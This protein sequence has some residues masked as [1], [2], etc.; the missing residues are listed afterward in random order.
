MAL[1]G[2]SSAEQFTSA[3]VL[4]ALHDV[5]TDLGGHARV[6]QDAM[7][8]EVY[9][10]L[11]DGGHLMVQAGTGTGKSL[12][13]LVPAL[14]WAD[15]N[16]TRVVIS[17]ATLALQRQIMTHDAP[18]VL[19]YFKRRGKIPPRI[20]LLK[21][22][23][24]YVCLRKASGGYPDDGALLSR[25]EGEYGATATGEQ[26]TRARDWAMST[27]T[28]DRDDLVP[29]V[30]ERAWAQISIPKSEC[31]GQS[32]PLRDACF[33]RLARIEAEKASVVVTNHAMLGVAT[34]GAQVLPD[35]DAF[36]VDEAHDLD[37]RV[38][39]QLTQTLMHTEI[40]RVA[41][42]LRRNG[43]DDLELE[44]CADNLDTEMGFLPEGR[45][46]ELPEGLS[47]VVLQLLG[48]LQNASEELSS[49]SVKGEEQSAAKQILRSR[50]MEMMTFCTDILGDGL[51]TKRSVAWK[52]LWG[53]DTPI[54]NLAPM[55]IA[56]NLAH[57]L[58]SEHAAVLTSATLKLGGSFDA[59]ARRVGFTLDDV[60]HWHGLDVGT[61]F[62]TVNQGVLYVAKHLPVPGREG[63][64]EEHLKEL[65]ELIRASRGG[66]LALF[67][68][69]A[70]AQRASEY[71]RHELPY[72]ILLQGEDQ[73]P[74]LVE[75]FRDSDSACLFG[76]YSLWQGVDV[77]GRTNRLVVI[78]R[79]PFPRPDDPLTQARTEVAQEHHH[80][81]FMNVSAT[82]AALLL[83]QGAGRL[84]RTHEDKGVVAILDSRIATR[85][86]SRFLLD[87]LPPMW[88]TTRQDVVLGV[89]QRLSSK[90]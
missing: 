61:P 73:L 17:T 76:T 77:P 65:T 83:A 24:N 81:G 59:I 16:N 35:A 22:W 33:P 78:D 89:L 54:L 2:D 47:G 39:S 25:A 49:W 51:A 40:K 4:D 52:S 44:I 64:G 46:T 45:I 28:G 48:Q 69:R 82:H 14:L 26:V 56:W 41:R 86:Y 63:Y 70:A 80:N 58:F 57:T 13:Y 7:A 11:L 29:G 27:D 23:N 55:N 53:D 74:T 12:G 60:G 30:S 5:I 68:S 38:T 88:A 72:E 15:A 66:A 43:L 87:S 50:M 37:S 1:D 85:S 67:T 3:D 42:M 75:R 71:V 79:I 18:L 62:D 36:I 6:G 90:G 10:A 34:T 9:E 19:Q 21:G 20:A 8:T 32:C 84:L 31:I